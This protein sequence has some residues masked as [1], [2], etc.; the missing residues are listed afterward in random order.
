MFVLQDRRMRSGRMMIGTK[1]FFIGYGV[2]IP[3]IWEKVKMAKCWGAL[4]GLS[5]AE[6]VAEDREA[7]WSEG[8]TSPS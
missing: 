5:P 8:E 4:R 1:N 6:R 2:K 7:G 3:R